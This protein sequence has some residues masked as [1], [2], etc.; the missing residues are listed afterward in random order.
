M[1]ASG[2]E[3]PCWH[4]V[5]RERLRVGR[6]PGMDEAQA[7]EAAAATSSSLGQG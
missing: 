7:K 2:Q 4:G 6:L 1:P 5:M 3:L